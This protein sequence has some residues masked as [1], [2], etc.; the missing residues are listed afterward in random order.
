M[1]ENDASLI[2]EKYKKEID[3][4]DPEEYG[5]PFGYEADDMVKTFV[6][7]NDNHLRYDEILNYIEENGEMVS[8]LSISGLTYD[9]ETESYVNGRVVYFTEEYKKEQLFEIF[10]GVLIDSK[11]C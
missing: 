7:L 3:N 9:P 8:G 1:K 11:I 5:L 10:G 6:I 2:Y 4:D